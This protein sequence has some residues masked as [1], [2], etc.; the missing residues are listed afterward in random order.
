MA[1]LVSEATS[2]PSRSHLEG[3]CTN[4]GKS[5][6]RRGE[7]HSTMHFGGP[8]CIAA[9]ARFPHEFGR[10]HSAMHLEGSNVI[11]GGSL[12]SRFRVR[13]GAGFHCGGT[14][15]ARSTRGGRSKARRMLLPGRTSLPESARGQRPHAIPLGPFA[16]P[17]PCAPEQCL[18]RGR[19]G[20]AEWFHHP[21]QRDVSC[22]QPG[23]S[24]RRVL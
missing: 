14:H 21:R 1:P 24:S 10:R 11:V 23:P 22:W 6:V 19:P 4:E 7:C 20:S 2:V 9:D 5:W 3:H 15:F 17:L 12:P 18:T 16:A 13:R 8:N